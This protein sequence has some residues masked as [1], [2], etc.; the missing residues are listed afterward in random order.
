M[1]LGIVGI[2][3]IV[4][5]IFFVKLFS[6]SLAET[7]KVIDEF[8][9]YTK[10]EDYDSAM[11]L[12]HE[13]FFTKTS[14]EELLTF[15]EIIDSELG[16]VE[17]Y[18][19]RNFDVHAISGTTDVNLQYVVNRTKFPSIESFSLRKDKDTDSSLITGYR[20]DSVGFVKDTIKQFTG[21]LG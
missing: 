4:L 17:D 5:I 20:V 2:L 11:T 3:L 15:L 19:L 14:E 1:V 13:V 8:Y 10:A 6:G 7:G 9:S 18:E 16:N 21:P 12:F